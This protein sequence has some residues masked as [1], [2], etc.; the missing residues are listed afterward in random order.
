LRA[1]KGHVGVV[2][3]RAILKSDDALPETI[4][5]SD[6]AEWLEIDARTV[7]RLAKAGIMVRAGHGILDFRRSVQ[8][9]VQYQ[10]ALAERARGHGEHCAATFMLEAVLDTL[11]TSPDAVELGELGDSVERMLRIR[12]SVM[13]DRSRAV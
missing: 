4:G 8:G 7:Q 3:E 13:R 1:E 6:L 2:L 12:A 11:R 5:T 10:A 9:Y